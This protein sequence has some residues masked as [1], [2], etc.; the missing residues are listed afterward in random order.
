MSLEKIREVN[1]RSVYVPGN[2]IDT[3]RIIPARFMKCVTFDGLGEYLFYDVRKDSNGNDRDHPL[4]ESRFSGSSIL[5]SNANFGCGS[6]REHAPQALYRY[7][8]R[9]VIAESFA[10]IFFGNCCALGMPCVVATQ[11]NIKSL[12][13]RINDVPET[14]VTVDV[15]NSEVCAGDLKFSVEIPEGAREALTN[16]RWDP[17][18]ELQEAEDSIDN[19]VTELGYLRR[20]R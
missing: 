7:G 1:G 13:E 20:G 12:A 2:D 5:I 11:E 3:D 4:N 15:M 19:L 10:E 8:F 6:S 18:A 17:I 14:Q 9:A 16:G